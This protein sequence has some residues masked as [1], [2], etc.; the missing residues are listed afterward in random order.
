[1][2]QYVLDAN[3]LFSGVMSQKAIYRAMFDQ[4]RYYTPDFVLAELNNYRKVL[5]KKSAVKGTD[6]KEFTL[7][8]FSKITVVPDYVITPDSYTRAELLVAEIDPKDVAYVAPNEELGTTLL[9]RDKP[10]YDG[11][12]AKGYTRIRLFNEFIAQQIIAHGGQ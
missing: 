7:F 8:L 2:N 6:L 5:L 12:T 11:L 1:M 3:V 4:N 9:T 10:L